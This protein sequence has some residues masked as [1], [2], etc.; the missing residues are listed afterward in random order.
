MLFVTNYCFVVPGAACP[1]L[2][3]EPVLGLMLD[4]VSF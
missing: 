1:V 3:V 4:A 2:S